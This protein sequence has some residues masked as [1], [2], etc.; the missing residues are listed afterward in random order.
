MMKLLVQRKS[1]ITEYWKYHLIYELLRFQENDI[2]GE[3]GGDNYFGIRVLQFRENGTLFD[4]NEVLGITE[5]YIEA[6][7]LFRKCVDGI[8]MPV[9]L[10]EL[11]DEWNYTLQSFWYHFK[12]L[13]YSQFYFLKKYVIIY[14]VSCW[15][16]TRILQQERW[17]VLELKEFISWIE[18]G[19]IDEI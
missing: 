5:D 13:S 2:E 17:G 18:R 10:T 16:M 19:E 15:R 14:L 11:V 4:Q 12:L 9:H 6:E 1:L 3:E 8:V 7:K